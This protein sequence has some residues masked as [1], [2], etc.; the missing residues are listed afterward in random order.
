MFQDC[1][2]FCLLTSSLCSIFLPAPSA[3]SPL[4]SF[5]S[6]LLLAPCPSLPSWPLLALLAPAASSKFGS[7][8]IN[9]QFGVNLMMKNKAH[10]T[11]PYQLITVYCVYITHSALQ[12]ALLHTSKCTL[13]T[14]Y[15]T[16]HTA[17]CLLHTILQ[18]TL[19]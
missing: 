6:F 10:F 5:C 14:V 18:Q 17:L 3:P 16:L 12:A 19:D 13:Y 11:L 7:H 1:A 15:C 4:F 2:I 9:R 8:F